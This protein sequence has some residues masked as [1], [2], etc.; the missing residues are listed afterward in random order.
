MHPH[1]CVEGYAFPLT[2]TSWTFISN[3]FKYFLDH[4]VLFFAQFFFTTVRTTCVLVH[5]CTES[6]VLV[7]CV[8]VESKESKTTSYVNAVRDGNYAEDTCYKDSVNGYI[9]VQF[10]AGVQLQRKLI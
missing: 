4:L 9:I 7:S 10:H 3:A 1:L 2:A 8:S 5:S 6:R